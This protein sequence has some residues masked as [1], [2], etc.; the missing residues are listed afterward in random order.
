M[1]AEFKNRMLLVHFPKN[2][3]PK[4]RMLEVKIE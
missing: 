3:N 2:E 1:K 4:A